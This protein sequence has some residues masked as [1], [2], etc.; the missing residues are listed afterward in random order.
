MYGLETEFHPYGFF[1]VHLRKQGDRV[2]RQAVR[3]GGD[4]KDVRQR[5]AEHR[6]VPVPEILGGSVGPGEAL[7]IGDDAAAPVLVG[8]EGGAVF[9]LADRVFSGE[10]EVP[11]PAAGS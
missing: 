5:M 2:V 9:Q 7:K 8:N 3:P 1:T 6:P 10:S 11:G 4:G